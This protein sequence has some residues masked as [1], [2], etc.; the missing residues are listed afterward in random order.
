[1]IEELSNESKNSF[2]PEE[3]FF[4]LLLYAPNKKEKYASSVRGNLWLQKEMFLLSKNL[5]ELKDLNFN[6]HLFGPY[7]PLLQSIQKQFINSK[8]IQQPYDTGPILL[9]QKGERIAKRLWNSI[10][11]LTK[12]T[13]KEIKIL[14]NDLDMWEVISFI[15]SSYPETTTNSDVIDGYNN[16]K[17]Q[18]AI[19]LFIKEKVSLEKAANIAGKPIE[20][21]IEIL[22]KNNVSAFEIDKKQLEDD[23][24]Y[25]ES[26]S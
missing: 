4:L 23:L 20:E 24:S 17:I 26:S 9:T 22:K 11:I 2:A 13:L 1:M 3:K 14:L 7:S 5:E 21:F 6:E 10:H 16:N 19:K 25:L 8:L 18:S 15:Y 12:N